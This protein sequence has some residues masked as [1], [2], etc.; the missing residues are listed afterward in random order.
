MSP[1]AFGTGLPGQ[2]H[3][4][5]V[6]QLRRLR[7]HAF[8]NASSS[9]SVHSEA[10]SPIVGS[11]THS[12]SPIVP[13]HVGGYFVLG[14][15]HRSS[16]HQDF[17]YHVPGGH[18]AYSHSPVAASPAGSNRSLPFHDP[19]ATPRKAAPAAAQGQ[20]PPTP[21]TVRKA[22]TVQ[23]HSRQGSG[24]ESVTYVR[25]HDGTGGN[26]RWVLERRR[27]GEQGLLELVGREVVEGGRI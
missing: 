25:E 27:T 10:I 3:E 5:S 18:V 24:A 23:T 21:Q 11:Y 13:P 4:T 19:D 6:E 7:G 20:A 26:P 8:G 16:T 1:L 2:E 9:A 22:K 14:T 12:Q 17:A 15:G